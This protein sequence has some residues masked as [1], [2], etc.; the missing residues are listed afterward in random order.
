MA[1]GI[2]MTLFGICPPAWSSIPSL[3]LLTWSMLL[4]PLSGESSSLV[5]EKYS[6]SLH[7]VIFLANTVSAF[8]RISGMS[9][10]IRHNYFQYDIRNDGYEAVC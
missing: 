9:M 7:A 8:L 10:D 3:P 2:P 6:V 5:T 1:S 4:K